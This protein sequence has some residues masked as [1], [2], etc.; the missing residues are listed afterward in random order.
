ME[1]LKVYR[2]SLPQVKLI[3]KR[4][5]NDDRDDS[6]TF[7][8]Y[9]Q[10]CF[11]EGW[12]DIL[13]H[14]KGIPGVS[15]DLVGAMRMT[16]APDGFE[17]WIGA[18]LAP[19]TEVPAGFEAVELP[20][21]E[22]GVCWLYGNDKNGELYSMEASDRSMAALAEKGWKI[23][24]NGW[25]FERYNCPRFTKPDEKGNVILDIGAYLAE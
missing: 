16:D 14:C 25:F 18:F 2:E 13:E 6:G 24:E 11:Q 15:D 4:Y 1:I 10:Q 7:A 9:W 3:G 20:A 17:Y 19:D 8:R 22:V 12:P 21:G 5:T 23:A